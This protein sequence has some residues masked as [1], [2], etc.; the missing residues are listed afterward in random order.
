MIK[1][2][3]A[4]TRQHLFT[5]LFVVAALLLS[6]TLQAAPLKLSEIDGA[7]SLGGKAEYLKSLEAVDLHSI[8]HTPDSL[9]QPTPEESRSLGRDHNLVWF[10]Q[11][12]RGSDLLSDD[13]L[14]KLDY[15]HY[16]YVDLY[17][18][19]DGELIE[20]FHTGDQTPFTTRPLP[21]RIFLFPLESIQHSADATIYLRIRT[22][23]PLLIPFSLVTG[24][25][26]VAQERS[27]VMWL[28]VYFGILGIMLAYNLFI[29]LSLRDTTYAYYLF[30]IA[31][32]FLQQVTLQ[33][34]GFQ[35]L[36]PDGEPINNNLAVALSTA[37]MQASAVG[38][39]I[40][41]I[42]LYERFPRFERVTGTVL[43]LYSWLL[44][45][46]APVMDYASFLAVVNVT[47]F[48]SVLAGIYIGIK[49]WWLGEKAARLFVLAWFVYLFFISWF[50]AE[51]ASL[52]PASDL[53]GYALAIGSVLELALLSIAFADKVN[54]EKEL[55]LSSQ[56][57]LMDVQIAMNAE[58]EEQ[59]RKR[60]RELE[61]ANQRLEI[62]STTDGLT[63]LLNRR[64]FDECYAEAYFDA[65]R[66]GSPLAV[67]MID[68]DHFKLL[69]DEYG[70]RFGDACL[71]DAGR[72]IREVTENH[73]SI[74]ARY[75]GEEFVVILPG[76][77][78][79]EAQALAESLRQAFAAHE[80]SAYG[81]S[82][83]MTVSI[84]LTVNSPV[85]SDAWEKLL[86][87]ADSLLYRAKR[88]GRNQVAF[89]ME[90]SA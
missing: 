79:R 17:L 29:F 36:W 34:I 19:S 51:L 37:L 44:V 26:A 78:A 56:S 71:V 25:T 47:G 69:N 82:R 45:A 38:F 14:L 8:M 28:G 66:T 58:L 75:G 20:S 88:N 24:K 10:R 31:T 22:E 41:F 2:T 64:R 57:Q 11:S 60:T 33:G 84:G 40:S 7:V 43:L 83:R 18:V 77:D 65:C 59:V 46:G 48:L 68:I 23:G 55:R 73:N 12:V 16:D 15:P 61:E 50:L 53:G 9:W 30:Y 80:V 74:C 39:V 27:V 52:I 1:T 4:A 3:T 81:M 35:Y 32:V 62:L 85:D 87:A 6:F 21:E 54:Q 76:A 63:G 70:H 13:F 86:Q 89:L 5:T 67:L 49:G 72:L 42:G 90:S